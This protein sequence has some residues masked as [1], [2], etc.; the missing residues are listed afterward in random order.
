MLS[1]AANLAYRQLTH[2]GAKLVG[3]LSGV[4][5]AV[6][7]MF[8]Q[9]GF[10]NALYD[11]AM[12]IP[13][14]MNT[15]LV[16]ASPQFKTMAFTP[17]WFSRGILTEAQG[18][19]GVESTL[20]MFALSIQLTNPESG[21]S[22]HAWLFGA[23]PYGRPFLNDDIN[24]LGHVMSLPN[25]VILDSASRHEYESLAEKVQQGVMP[26]VLFPFA[27]A[28]LQQSIDIRGLFTLGASFTIDGTLITSD[29]NF[30]RLTSI[31]M[32]RISLGLVRLKPGA[33]AEQIKQD[34]QSVLGDRVKVLSK[35]EFIYGEQLYYANN[36]PIGYIF[37]AGLIV[38]IVVGVVFISQALHGIISDNIKEYAVLRAM[39]YPD[40][41]FVLQIGVVSLSIALI[42]YLPSVFIASGF[43]A[44]AAGAIKLPLQMKIADMLSILFM[45][46]GMGLVATAMA[47]RKLRKA[48]PVD[49]FS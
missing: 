46:A 8:T 28:S 14:S 34:L 48:N 5:V 15:D 27:S 26:S 22:L 40:R 45:V 29:L 9:V 6:V 33:D 42:T 18:V 19:E 12:N 4:C 37:R 30:H 43:Y 3:A 13:R 32:D 2:R 44:L 49:L 17:P 11:S 1:V 20:P 31:P 10:Q 41:F 36:T 39:G 23:S 25:A 21:K 24:A 38:G 7:L 16:L 47:T 35:E